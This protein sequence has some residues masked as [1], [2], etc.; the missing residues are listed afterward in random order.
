MGKEMPVIPVDRVMNKK[1][2][3]EKNVGPTRRRGGTMGRW[4][5]KINKSTAR[6]HT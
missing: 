1:I 6:V 5:Q 3:I 4:P 2:V